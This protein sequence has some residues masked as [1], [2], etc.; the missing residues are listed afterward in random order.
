VPTNYGVN[1]YV[2]ELYNIRV[3]IDGIEVS[4]I[5][6]LDFKHKVNSSRVATLSFENRQT[7]ESL[8]I[9]SVI[10]INFGLS[11]AYANKESYV[12]ISIFMECRHEVLF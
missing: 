12:Q 9:G 2:N 7:L 6:S 8:S 1:Q 11:D 5:T 3:T 10:K 4:G